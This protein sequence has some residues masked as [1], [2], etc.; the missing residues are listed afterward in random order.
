MTQMVLVLQDKRATIRKNPQHHSIVGVF[1][2]LD[3]IDDF[4]KENPELYPSDF[5]VYVRTI[6]EVTSNTFDIVS[7][8]LI[9]KT[10]KDIM[11]A[12]KDKYYQA[13]TNVQNRS[14]FFHRTMMTNPKLNPLYVDMMLREIF[15]TAE[16]TEG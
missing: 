13:I 12:N 2:S 1:S 8:T 10:I 6:N 4:F 3:H 9:E 5:E 7:K 11:Y 16:K 14:W 15:A